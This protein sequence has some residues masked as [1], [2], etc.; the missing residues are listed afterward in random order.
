MGATSDDGAGVSVP[1][2][3]VDGTY[4]VTTGLGCLIVLIAVGVLRW[5]RPVFVE[6]NRLPR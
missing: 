1:G 6:E 2:V 3:C 4:D 5:W